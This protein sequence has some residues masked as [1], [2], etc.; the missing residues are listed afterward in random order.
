MI[1]PIDKCKYER[2][3]FDRRVDK[4]KVVKTEEVKEIV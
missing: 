3:Q 2:Q 4:I 1:K